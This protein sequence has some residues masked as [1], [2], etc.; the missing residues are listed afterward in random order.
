M[1]FSHCSALLLHWWV[2]LT[3]DLDFAWSSAAWKQ[4]HSECDWVKVSSAERW[5][6]YP[7]P[8]PHSHPITFC[9]TMW[10]L[11]FPSF[12]CALDS[13][14]S[15]SHTFP[16]PSVFTSENCPDTVADR[17][18]DHSYGFPIWT[19]SQC[20]KYQKLLRKE[21]DFFSSLKFPSPNYEWVS[22]QHITLFA[23]PW[24]VFFLNDRRVFSLWYPHPVVGSTQIGKDTFDRGC[25][26]RQ[27]WSCNIPKQ[28][29]CCKGCQP[30]STKLL[31]INFTELQQ[32]QWTPHTLFLLKDLS[33]HALD[34]AN[35]AS[36]GMS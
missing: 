15:I 5:F 14:Q 11:F 19:S 12:F 20:L 25:T 3:L 4:F 9:F 27:M 31:P 23:I 35:Q 16:L 7:T 36:K 10:A 8:T 18:Q 2:P 13:W 33:W 6:S 34:N 21:Y 32:K 1:A 22:T 26:M 28:W 17:A 30:A 29:N 24:H